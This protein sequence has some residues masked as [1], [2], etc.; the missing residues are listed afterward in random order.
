[1]IEET[2]RIF[3]PSSVFKAHVSYTVPSST[4]MYALELQRVKGLSALPFTS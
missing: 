1:M 4:Q 2:Y 3:Q